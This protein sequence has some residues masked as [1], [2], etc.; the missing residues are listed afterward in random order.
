MRFGQASFG[1]ASRPLPSEPPKAVNTRLLN[2]TPASVLNARHT[3]DVVHPSRKPLI[4]S[5]GT[6]NAVAQNQTSD[7]VQSNRGHPLQAPTH[8]WP[9][10]ESGPSKAPTRMPIRSSVSRNSETPSQSETGRARMYTPTP[11]PSTRIIRPSAKPALD[12]RPSYKG[13]SKTS[14]PTESK[15]PVASSELGTPR[16]HL[17]NKNLP[18]AGVQVPGPPLS[19]RAA[20]KQ[21][22][23]SVSSPV[24]TSSPSVSR[25]QTTVQDQRYKKCSRNHPGECWPLCSMCNE[26][27]IGLCR[28]LV[29]CK[30]CLKEHSGEWC[31][32]LCSKCNERHI[33]SCRYKCII[34]TRWHVGICREV[35][36]APAKNLPLPQ[37]VAKQDQAPKGAEQRGATTPKTAQRNFA[38]TTSMPQTT[39]E[40]T[41]GKAVEPELT[42]CKHRRKDQEC[43]T[44][45]CGCGKCHRPGKKCR[46]QTDESRKKVGEKRKADD[47]DEVD[48]ADDASVKVEPST[49]PSKPIPRP[50]KKR[51]KEAKVKIKVRDSTGSWYNPIALDE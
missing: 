31:G 46:K 39:I 25:A 11:G 34:C 7:R 49:S 29:C 23:R 19:S 3:S 2:T 4:D 30:K 15:K 17:N 6:P 43:V 9:T 24:D 51:K 33:G 32:P 28:G 38:T 14:G 8:H 44:C 5:T 20:G 1:S 26:H 45:N 47:T 16:L 35:S 36:N 40:P 10:P 50:K 12:A 13:G 42:S 41:P 37:D 22:A 18:P 27:H 48:V 21:P